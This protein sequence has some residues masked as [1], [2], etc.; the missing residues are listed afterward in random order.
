MSVKKSKNYSKV[1]PELIDYLHEWIVNYPQ[2][3]NSPIS[4]DTLL[5]P[6]HKQP[7]KEIRVSKFLFQISINELHNNL[8]SNISIYQIKEEIEEKTGKP[9]IIETALCAPMTNI[10]QNVIGRYN[11]MYSYKICVIICYMQA[12]LNYY[13]LQHIN[14]LK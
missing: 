7:G 11:Q 2:V 13:R 10:Y 3:V 4:N 1:T 5:V 12:S 9:L 14:L 6:N 8:I